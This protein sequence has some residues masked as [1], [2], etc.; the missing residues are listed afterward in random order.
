MLSSWPRRCGAVCR[1]RVKD[2]SAAWF[3][4][5]AGGREPAYRGLNLA[6]ASTLNGML[7]YRGADPMKSESGVRTRMAFDSARTRLATD[8]PRSN[9]RGGSFVLL[10]VA[11]PA[12]VD[13]LAAA[14]RH[15]SP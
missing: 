4:R 10:N 1:S 14:K 3:A 5:E 9:R 11:V 6:A 12:S 8:R 13:S 2:S 7:K 15:A